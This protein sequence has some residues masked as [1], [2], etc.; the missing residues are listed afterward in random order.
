M[1]LP[2]MLSVFQT[3]FVHVFFFYKV[4]NAFIS[5]DSVQTKKRKRR[6]VTREANEIAVLAVVHQNPQVSTR[7]L[8]RDSGISRDSIRRIL[9]HH[10]YHPYHISLYQELHGD[11]FHNRE[12]FCEWALQ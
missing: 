7:Q 12:V 5:D 9:H 1:L 10:K 6:T 2:C 11:D 8:H 3:M 4:V